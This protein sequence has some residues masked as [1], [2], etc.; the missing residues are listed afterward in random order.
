MGDSERVCETRWLLQVLDT[1]QQFPRTS[2]P[3]ELADLL[4]QLSQLVRSDEAPLAATFA[5]EG[6]RFRRH[7]L[8]TVEAMGCSA[9]LMYWPAGHATLPHDHGGLWGIEVVIDGRLHVE[10]FVKSGTLDRPVLTHSRS[11]QLAAG[12]GAMFANRQYVHRCRN[13]SNV[14]PTLTLHVY[15]GYLTDYSA[16]DFGADGVLRVQ[17]HVARSDRV[18]S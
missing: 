5:A 18:L 16:Y 11:F 10:E 4:D 2:A 9:L 3:H 6:D 7:P 12:D 8:A 17:P 1:L 13:L 14:E 15:G